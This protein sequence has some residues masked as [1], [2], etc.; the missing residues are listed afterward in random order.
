RGPGFPV[1]PDANNQAFLRAIRNLDRSSGVTAVR[2][3]LQ[4]LITNYFTVFAGASVSPAYKQ[5]KDKL[6][7]WESAEEFGLQGAASDV[8]REYGVFETIHP[9]R[10][11][12][13]IESYNFYSYKRYR[14]ETEIFWP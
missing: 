8:D 11:G 14:I 6:L 7:R 13:V 3:A 9:T 1:I 4:D 10:L 12:N 5:I 2:A